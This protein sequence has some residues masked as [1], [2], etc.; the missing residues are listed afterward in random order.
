MAQI[1]W[2]HNRFI[3]P[4]IKDT[5]EAIFYASATLENGWSRDQLTIQIRN[6]YYRTKGKAVTNFKNLY[7]MFNLSDR[8]KAG[9]IHFASAMIMTGKNEKLIGKKYLLTWMLLNLSSFQK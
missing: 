3:I 7:R 4:K 2:G 9:R 6:D 1:P 5:R 8:D